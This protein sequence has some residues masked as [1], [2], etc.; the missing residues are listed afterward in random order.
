MCSPSPSRARR[1]TTSSR[2]P[3]TAEQLGFGAF[4]RSD[5][6]LAMGSDGLPGPT[7]AWTTLAGPR[8]RHHH[9]PARHPDDQ[10]DVPPPRRARD[11]GRR[12]RRDERRPGRAGHRRRLV[13]PQEHTAYGIP[14]PDTKERFERYAEQLEIVTGLWSTPPEET[15][16]FAGEHYQLADSPALPKPVQPT[17][18][19]GGPP[20]LIGGKGKKQTPALA[21]VYAD[22]FNLPFVDEE[23][24]ARQ[25]AR[26][27]AAC[28]A[29]RPRPGRPDLVQRA[30]VSASGGTRPRSPAGPR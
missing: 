11:P 22:E 10:R 12:R 2:L 19:R 8:P 24:T 16:D 3:A 18:H 26:V 5:H 15:Y 14:F 27:R 28:E 25:F 29:D 20:V 21:A 23:T 4:F 17:G 30:D 13:R 7:D 6:Y 9:H 1:T